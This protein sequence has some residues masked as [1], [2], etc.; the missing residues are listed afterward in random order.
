MTKMNYIKS[1]DMFLEMASPAK[2]EEETIT[3]S[4]HLSDI[5][6]TVSIPAYDADMEGEV[7]TLKATSGDDYF[8][9]FE[10]EPTER[11]LKIVVTTKDN[12]ATL[13][14]LVQLADFSQKPN[15]EAVMLYLDINERFGTLAEFMNEITNQIGTA[16]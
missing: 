11:K 15:Q 13:W 10:K 5:Y 3:V 16:N 4:A 6:S 1:Y 8:V 2:M 14:D 12:T 7:L 9:S